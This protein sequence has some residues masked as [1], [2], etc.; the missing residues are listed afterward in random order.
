MDNAQETVISF[1]HAGSR[2]IT[3]VSGL[4]TGALT[5]CVILIAPGF[6]SSSWTASSILIFSVHFK[7][8]IKWWRV[9]QN[10]KSLS[11]IPFSFPFCLISWDSQFWRIQTG[12]T[13]GC[14]ISI[15]YKSHHN[16][17]DPPI[18]MLEGQTSG[19]EV[20]R[21][22]HI[23]SLEIGNQERLAKWGREEDAGLL[24]CFSWTCILHLG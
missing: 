22:L 8:L 9:A 23:S 5:C 3:Q 17:L 16:F 11:R 2:V 6:L 13:L 20:L 14:C 4:A 21:E 12:W 15:I 24:V 7:L 18:D 1:H 10:S 19:L